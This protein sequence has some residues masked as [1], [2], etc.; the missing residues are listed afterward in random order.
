MGRH[1]SGSRAGRA[2]SG[3]GGGAT[4]GAGRPGSTGRGGGGGGGLGGGGGGG[5]GKPKK[6]VTRAA[7]QQ[8]RLVASQSLTE[9]NSKHAA[10]AAAE[11]AEQPPASV[12]ASQLSPTQP[13]PSTNG[14]T[15][16]HAG[17]AAGQNVLLNTS[18]HGNSDD[19]D[20][21]GGG[22]AN[23]EDDNGG[24]GVAQPL[25]NSHPD[26]DPADTPLE[27]T[28]WVQ[29]S[30][31]H[32]GSALAMDYPQ[33]PPPGYHPMVTILINDRGL[34]QN[35]AIKQANVLF[36]LTPVNDPPPQPQQQQQN[37]DLGAAPAAANVES[38]PATKQQQ[39]QNADQGAKPAAASGV[40]ERWSV[41]QAAASA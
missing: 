9:A 29:S 41:T 21:G 32:Q 28:G 7:A 19:G 31:Q 39:Q 4:G 26:A 5:V 1:K 30:P 16:Q 24:A 40:S 23:N 17:D 13:T 34:T 10:G 22:V 15:Q 3:R 11:Q 37:A 36:E 33:K 38:E 20:H 6:P 14:S 8:L 35:E 2:Q 27:H 25:T 18:A 12:D